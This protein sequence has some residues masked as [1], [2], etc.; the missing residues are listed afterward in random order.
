MYSTRLV[1]KNSV[2]GNAYITI[3]DPF[4]ERNENPFR[5]SK[6]SDKTPFRTKMKPVNEENGFFSKT[7]YKAG[8]FQ[9]GIKYKDTQPLD[10]RKKGFG[11]KDAHKRDEFSNTMSTEQYRETLKK[12]AFLAATRS[13]NVQEELEALLASRTHTSPVFNTTAASDSSDFS[14][15]SHVPLF[16]IGRS[17]ITPFDARSIKDTFYKFNGNRDKRFGSYRPSSC[18]VGLSAWDTVYRPPS[19]GGKS[20]TKNF[21][22]KSHL[23]VA[24]N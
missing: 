3:G 19:H 4:K 6:K 23:N 8:G 24:N 15:D 9:E 7:T 2:D 12:E 11:T 5:E 14:Y 10:Q 16:D 21:F 20:E 17:R 1:H 22:D 18:D 13:G